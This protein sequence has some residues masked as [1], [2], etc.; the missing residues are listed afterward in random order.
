MI[1]L[2]S[3]T[4]TKPS[5][6]MLEAMVNA[7]LGDDVFAED[8]T[9]N[10]LQQRCAELTGKD[11]ALFVPTG[12]MANQLAVKAH[13]NS[14]DEIICEAECHIFNYETAA[15]A[16]IS[17]VLVRQLPGTSGYFSRKDLEQAI[18]PPD[19]YYPKSS[20]MCL[21]NTHNRAGGAIIPID[22]IEELTSYAKE[23]GLKR[24]LDGARI[25]NA[26]VETGIPIKEYA[27][28]FDTISFCF[29]KGLGAPVGSILCGDDESITKA[30]KWRKILGGGMR[31]AGVLA[32]AGLYALDNNIERLKEDNAR[33]K[34]FAEELSRIDGF[35][36][37]PSNVHTNIIIF[38][39]SRIN[40]DDLVKKLSEKGVLI[41]FGNYDFLRIV[42]HLGID[43]ADLEKA[44]DAFKSL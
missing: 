17:D 13:T 6:Q 2:R 18:R 21:E 15:P 19:Y 22:A 43:D 30:H 41:S 34:K 32:A 28:H 4:V 37:D 36:I 3:D 27:S 35:E 24:H 23:R 29:S 26:S 42:F 31:Q 40:K 10:K 12:C 14:G 5:K 38:A 11:R 7:D 44:L 25:F 33:A 39:S 20:L 9:V 16:I 8:P 1:D